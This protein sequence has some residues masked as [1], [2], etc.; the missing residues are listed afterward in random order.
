VTVWDIEKV[1][2]H[3]VFRPA[4]PGTGEGEKYHTH[5]YELRNLEDDK[6]DGLLGRVAGSVSNDPSISDA[7][8]ARPAVASA[9]YF[10]QQQGPGDSESQQPFAVTGGP[11][12]K[13]RF[14]DC[15]RLDGCRLVSGGAQ[16]EKPT[17]AFS[18]LNLDTKIWSEKLADEDAQ[19]MGSPVESSKIAPGGSGKRAASSTG[20]GKQSRFD[21]IRSSV[22]NLLDGHLDTVTDVAVLEKPFGM[23]LSADRSGQVFVHQ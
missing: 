14:W 10:G 12:G 6:Y 16:D 20:S 3:E 11:D 1:I 23:V 8:A 7:A 2:C 19:P 5:D 21:T 15:E 17:Y 18:H 9:L 13:V 4:L 22:Q